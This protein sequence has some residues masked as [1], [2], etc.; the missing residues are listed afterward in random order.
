MHDG[1][2]HIHFVATS[3][4]CDCA[5]NY[6]NW[7]RINKVIVEIRMG[8]FLKHSSVVVKDLRFKDKD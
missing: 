1:K 4:L 2:Q 5:K 3:L 7:F 8:V 6:Q